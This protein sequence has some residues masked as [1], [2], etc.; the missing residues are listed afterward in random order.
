MVWL[1]ILGI[2][3]LLAVFMVLTIKYSSVEIDPN[4][5]I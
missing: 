3:I 2:F 4:V 1:I 5:E